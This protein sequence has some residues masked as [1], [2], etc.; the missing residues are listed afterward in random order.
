[1]RYNEMIKSGDIC[2]K[3]ANR[4]K[5]TVRFV[6]VVLLIVLT[7]CPA[8]AEA[9][10]PVVV[11]VGDFTY[12]QS[13]VQG[14]LDSMR[15]LTQV[16]EG[17]APSEEVKAERVQATIDSFVRLGVI[18]NKLA[19]AGK[20]DFTKTEQN[21][22]DQTARTKYEEMWQALYQQ[23]QQSD[24]AVSEKTVTAN[25][26][27]MGFTYDTIYDELALQMRQNRAIE[28]YCSDVVITQ[29][30]VDAYYEVQFVAPD[31]ENYMISS[32]IWFNVLPHF[33]IEMKRPD[34]FLK[35]FK[36]YQYGTY[37]CRMASRSYVPTTKAR[38]TRIC[39]GSTGAFSS[40]CKLC[41]TDSSI[42]R[43][44]CSTC[45]LKAIAI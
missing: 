44:I 18:E 14:S 2:G 43:T 6:W 24:P 26:E 25:L 5:K 34:V 16:L 3:S 17:E 38:G 15:D 33:E 11:R 45:R 9:A 23:M 12:T 29:A 1:M 7:L 35:L 10:D 39:T 4:M 13:V 32:V 19:E 22:L 20:D 37:T 30:Q 27:G 28:M 36:I 41:C 42:G 31:R 40:S 21:E 8:L